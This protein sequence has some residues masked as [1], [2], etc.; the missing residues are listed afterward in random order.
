M[1][2]PTEQRRI[3]ANEGCRRGAE[4]GSRLCASCDLEWTLFH[5]ERRAGEAG[6]DGA[7]VIRASGLP[8]TDRAV[9]LGF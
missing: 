7:G 2:N 5:R 3:C 6:G 1:K 9:S 8:G 4:E